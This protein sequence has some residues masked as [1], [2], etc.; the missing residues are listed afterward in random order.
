MKERSLVIFTILCQTAVGAF[1]TLV[2]L[3][4]YL[5]AQ[6]GREITEVL[7]KSILAGIVIILMIGLLTSLHH[8]G[9]PQKAWRALS[10]LRRSWLSREI[11]CAALFT[12]IVSVYTGLQCLSLAPPQ[13]QDLF[14]WFALVWGIAFVYS[15]SRVYSL[16]TVPSWNSR[17]TWWSFFNTPFLLGGLYCFTIYIPTWLNQPIA[18]LFEVDLHKSLVIPTQW[19]G[20]AALL[21]IGINFLFTLITPTPSSDMPIIMR[22]LNLSPRRIKMLR[23]GILLCGMFAILLLLIYPIGSPITFLFISTAF[24]TSLAALTLERAQFY[25]SRNPVF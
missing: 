19:I 4:M 9:T 25:D 20:L 3:R 10:N 22:I 15:M 11:F 16:R 7:S 1:L 12:L 23:S 5:I 17:L 14:E 8:L 2:L 6:F 21:L 18:N 24:V 13:V